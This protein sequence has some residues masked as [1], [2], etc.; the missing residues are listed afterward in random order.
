MITMLASLFIVQ[1]AS[2]A[3]LSQ[4]TKP[5]PPVNISIAPVQSG[6]RSSNIK[7]GDSVEFRVNIVSSIDASEM[8]VFNTLDGGAELIA[9]DLS[10][11]GEVQKGQEVIVSL[12]VRAPQKG[13]G[14][15]TSRVEIYSGDVLLYSSKAV[16]ELGAP[17]KDKPAPPRGIM[18]D[19]KGHSVVEYR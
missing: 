19:S 12:S 9:G 15:I 1:D 2:S 11:S 7:P 17:E 4:R 5:Q 8:R 10:W 14:K 18:K 3:T 13:K 16:Y 6:L